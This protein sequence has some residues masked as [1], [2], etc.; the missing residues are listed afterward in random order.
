MLRRPQTL[1]AQALRSW[2]R[3][4]DGGGRAGHEALH[5]SLPG[6]TSLLGH[7]LPPVVNELVELGIIQPD[8]LHVA[9]DRLRGV[10]LEL[11]T[12]DAA[13]LEALCAHGGL[14]PW[15]AKIA[16][17]GKAAWL[18]LGPYVLCR[19]LRYL[20]YAWCYAGRRPD[21][22]PERFVLVADLDGTATIHDRAIA[23]LLDASSRLDAFGMLPVCE[24]GI[25]NSRFWAA[26]PLVP[27]TSLAEFLAQHGRMAADMVLHAAR[28]MT[29]ALA[30]CERAGIV[31]GDIRAEQVLLRETGEVLLAMPGVRGLLRPMESTSQARGEPPWLQSV[32]P[33]RLMHGAPP[34]ARSDMYACG[35]LWW[36]MLTGRPRCGRASAMSTGVPLPWR[37]HRDLPPDVPEA[38]VKAIDQCTQWDE[39]CRPQSFAQLAA[40]LG[41]PTASGRK[42]LARRLRSQRGLTRWLADRTALE[43]G[44]NL[45]VQAVAALAACLAVCLVV[46]WPRLTD[47]AVAVQ[48]GTAAAGQPSDRVAV[49]NGPA[50]PRRSASADTGERT[51]RDR[52]A[53]ERPQAAARAA[54]AAAKR[55]AERQ[56]TAERPTMAARPALGRRSTGEPREQVRLELLL[57]RDRLNYL[58]QL[59][60]QPGM[61]V[62]PDGP[63]RAVVVA[64]QESTPLAANDLRFVHVDF[65]SAA[66]RW[67]ELGASRPAKQASL[68]AATPL[69]RVLAWSASFEDCTFQ[70]PGPHAA[71]EWDP[72]AGQH[73]NMNTG[74]INFSCCVWHTGGPAIRCSLDRSLVLHL[75][76]S[77]VVGPVALVELASWPGSDDLVAIHLSQVTLRGMQ[78]VVSCLGRAAQR[79]P[80][81]LIV[82]TKRCVLDMQADG[83]LVLFAAG[84]PH[85]TCI[86]QLCWRGAG[87]VLGGT[88]PV[89]A[90]KV[91]AQ[92]T[93]PI[94]EDGAAIRGLVRGEL[95]F[96]GPPDELPHG[97]ALLEFRAPLRSLDPPGAHIAT[98]PQVPR[99]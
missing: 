16:A 90:W 60:L 5:A 97:S 22:R 73:N 43:T 81:R 64:G 17:A 55:D 35:V 56:L 46:I 70:Q 50:R 20:G 32:A 67:G 15:Q 34:S 14:T 30:A 42:A 7:A 51:V 93:L 99:R 23:R 79:P 13:W 98:L 69:L 92:D 27:H 54:P 31:H 37:W 77:L 1:F 91:G 94:E 71:L 76:D 84:P 28:I 10:P 38:L 12:Y 75:A 44:R 78:A 86:A 45:A 88:A 72:H 63:G 6:S 74:T 36:Q 80:G 66:G 68:E 8:A 59:E 19:P 48:A 87:S 57:P 21:A 25:S 53:T 89:L 2:Q 18:R 47:R 41:S 58:H 9:W 11:L 85:N 33:E 83:A 65:V 49:A 61:V 29:C 24:A 62:R 39:A 3:A 40:W 4:L 95:H 96:A 82:E 26:V 52:A